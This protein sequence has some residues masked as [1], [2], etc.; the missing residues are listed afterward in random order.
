MEFPSEQE[1][2]NQKA[3]DN[4]KITKWGDLPTGI[5]Y[6]IKATKAINGKYGTSVVADLENRDGVKFKTWLPRR[7][8]DEVK[9]RELP[10]FVISE[11][12]MPCKKS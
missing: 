5:V 9:D 2:A 12:L 7:L 1:L 10:V 11:G 8:G 6:A 3:K 4:I